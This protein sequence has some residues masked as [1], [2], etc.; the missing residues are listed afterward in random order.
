MH[1][2][3]VI[4]FMIYYRLKRN[5]TGLANMSERYLNAR[6]LAQKL[7]LSRMTI[8]R[9]EKS[10][11]FPKKRRLSVNSYRWI[12]SEIEEW[13]KTRPVQTAGEEI[14]SPLKESKKKA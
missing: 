11:D 10:G 9:L 5:G 7:N 13:I 2:C 8:W 1:E 6:E 4:F 3:D 12:E 14:I